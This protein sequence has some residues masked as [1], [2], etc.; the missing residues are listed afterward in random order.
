MK[1]SG[2]KTKSGGQKQIDSSLPLFVKKLAKRMVP[3]GLTL[4]NI[5]EG[6]KK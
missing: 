2:L 5:E 3:E 6:D 1:E 4:H